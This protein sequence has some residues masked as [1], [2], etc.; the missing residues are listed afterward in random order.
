MLTFFYFSCIFMARIQTGT[1]KTCVYALPVSC[2]FCPHK[3]LLKTLWL[4]NFFFCIESR[5]FGILF[6]SLLNE[7]ETS[8]RRGD[9]LRIVMYLCTIVG[10]QKITKT[11]SHRLR[12]E[13]LCRTR[14]FKIKGNFRPSQNAMQT[15]FSRPLLTFLERQI[16][17]SSLAASYIKCITSNLQKLNSS[18]GK[19]ETKNWV[20]WQSR[21]KIP[22][23][24]NKTTSDPTRLAFVRRFFS[25]LKEPRVKR[26]TQRSSTFNQG[27]AND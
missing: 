4:H 5:P 10:F 22:F 8:R 15:R 17:F 16:V 6:C 24:S 1:T 19:E 11:E 12:H 7:R 2:C 23:R 18:A 9:E 3:S 14:K 20:D 13:V 26:A 25:F 21:N 27:R